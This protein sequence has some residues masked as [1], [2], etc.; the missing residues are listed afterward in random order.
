ML[1]VLSQ[2]TA[3][4]RIL[5]GTGDADLYEAAGNDRIWGIGFYAND[6]PTHRAEWGE[7]RLGRCLMA[8]REELRALRAP[9]DPE[10]ESAAHVGSANND[11]CAAQP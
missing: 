9:R 4:R 10:A 6:A 5:L 3:I 2:N 1:I 7:N 11:A 8:I